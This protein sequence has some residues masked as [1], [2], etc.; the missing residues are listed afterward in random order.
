MILQRDG[1]RSML[2]WH[3][4]WIAFY[5]LPAL[6]Q[7]APAYPPTTLEEEHHVPSDAW[8]V[9]HDEDDCLEMSPLSADDSY[10][11]PFY[12]GGGSLLVLLVVGWMAFYQYWK[13][14][15]FKATCYACYYGKRQL[16][17]E[18]QKGYLQALKLQT[19]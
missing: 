14:L 2:R 18:P 8:V 10:I 3:G 1:R 6:A 5:L 17:P 19:Y 13:H 16:D 7:Q 12:I 4:L 9:G 15:P 11:N